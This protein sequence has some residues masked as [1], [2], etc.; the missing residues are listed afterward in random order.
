MSDFIL[1][2]FLLPP[3]FT[4]HLP[5]QCPGQ[6]GLFLYRRQTGRSSPPP[7]KDLAFFF[8]PPAEG[9]IRKIY[10]SVWGLTE[11][12]EAWFLFYCFLGYPKKGL[13]T[14]GWSKHRETACI[15]ASHE[16]QAH[17]MESNMAI[18]VF[19]I[20]SNHSVRLETDIPIST[21]CSYRQQVSQV[22]QVPRGTGEKSANRKAYLCLPQYPQHL[23]C[24][25]H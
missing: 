7:E 22:S 13:S 16:N 10:M 4:K 8:F 15:R 3:A 14:M 19:L 9:K 2:A 1:S 25:T 20:P 23:T 5:P 17:W 6:T 18:L 21:D 24:Q 11:V 12:Q